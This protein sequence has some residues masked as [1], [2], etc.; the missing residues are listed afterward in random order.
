MALLFAGLALVIAYAVATVL[1]GFPLA[2]VLFLVGFS[3]L[4]GYRH[5]A[6]LLL[7]AFGTTLVLLYVFVY[8]VYISL[9]L[10]VGPFVDLNV[11]LYRLL[12]IF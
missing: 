12:G 2:T 4:G 7:V 10:G 3:C 8:L 6:S 5:V 11:A 1:I 9:P